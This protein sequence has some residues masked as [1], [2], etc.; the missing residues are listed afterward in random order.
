MIELVLRMR[1]REVWPVEEAM[2]IM[3]V[4]DAEAEAGH[5]RSSC[6][7]VKSIGGVV[8]LRLASWQVVR[9]FA[10]DAQPHDLGKARC[11]GAFPD[12]IMSVAGG[13]R[14]RL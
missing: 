6:H 11:R 1:E 5:I 7:V 4:R 13:V 14:G 12:A 9:L 10:C 3:A 2:V 8:V